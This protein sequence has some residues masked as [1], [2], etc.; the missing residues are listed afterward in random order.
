[1][2]DIVGPA[3]TGAL[4]QTTS[5]Q[6]NAWVSCV[7]GI[8]GVV[9][10]LLTVHE[11]LNKDKLSESE[12]VPEPEFEPLPELQLECELDE[13]DASDTIGQGSKPHE[14]EDEE[15]CEEER[16]SCL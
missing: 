8:A 16:K 13:D 5:L 14:K 2:G 12:E 9:W 1:M 3:V 4:A 7:V 6:V 11:T 15:S 10:L